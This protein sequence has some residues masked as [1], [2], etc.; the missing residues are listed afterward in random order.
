MSLALFICLWVSFV[1]GCF[2]VLHQNTLSEHFRTAVWDPFLLCNNICR[3]FLYSDHH[4]LYIC[5]VS[6][7]CCKRN[8]IQTPALL[9]RHNW[10][11]D[12]KCFSRNNFGLPSCFSPLGWN[13]SRPDSRWSKNWRTDP[14]NVQGAQNLGTFKYISISAF[15]EKDKSKRLTEGRAISLNIGFLLDT[16]YLGGPPNGVVLFV[17]RSV[18]ATIC[19]D[20]VNPIMAQMQMQE[21]QKEIRLRQMAKWVRKDDPK[22]DIGQRRKTPSKPV[23]HSGFSFRP[24]VQCCFSDCHV[25]YK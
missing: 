12:N 17:P 1:I 2:S 20:E 16:N 9:R 19:N 11:I 24:M 15:L 14:V 4:L 22:E 10:I 13:W 3:D 23:V 18:R 8:S 25:Q 7:F 6:T 5:W 21:V